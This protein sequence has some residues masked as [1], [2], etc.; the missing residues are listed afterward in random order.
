MKASRNTTIFGEI[1]LTA[2]AVAKFQT[3]HGIE[4]LGGV[5]P[6]TR[7]VL[8]TLAT[9]PDK[10]A[11]IASLLAQVKALQAQIAALLAA[12]SA[13]STATSTV[14]AAIAAGGGGSPAVGTPATISNYTPPP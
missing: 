7:A 5:G 14:T 2:N 3:A 11:L 1:V 12:Q 8:N 6:K 13:T 10:A 4:A 9:T